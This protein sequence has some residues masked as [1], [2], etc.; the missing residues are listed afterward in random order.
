MSLSGQYHT[1]WFPRLLPLGPAS[2]AGVSGARPDHHVVHRHRFNQSQTIFWSYTV[3]AFTGLLWTLSNWQSPWSSWKKSYIRL[4]LDYSTTSDVR[5]HD[6]YSIMAHIQYFI[7]TTEHWEA[8]PYTWPLN[9]HYSRS[10]SPPQCVVIH[11]LLR[12]SLDWVAETEV[13]RYR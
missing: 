3:D 12:I 9:I 8:P 1:Y 5:W 2:F 11:R 7:P 13:S 4:Q 10:L 6:L